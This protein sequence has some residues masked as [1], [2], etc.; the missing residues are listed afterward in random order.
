MTSRQGRGAFG[1][2]QKLV[3]VGSGGVGKSAIT[4]RF[5]TSQFYDQAYNPTIEDSYR[6]Q[7]VVDDEVVTLEIL[8]TAGQEE[9]GAMAD[10]WYRYGTGFLL[11]YS[12]TDRPTFEALAGLHQNILRVKDKEGGNVPCVVVSNKA[13]GSAY[14]Y[15]PCIVADTSLTTSQCDLARLRQVGQLEGRDLAKSFGAPFI[16]CSAADGV[17]VEIAFRELV[18]LVRRDERV[19]CKCECECECEHGYGFGYGKCSGV[20]RL[21]VESL[22]PLVK[23]R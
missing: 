11:V 13:S 19:R 8:D 6:K 20:L 22:E 16:E 7:F 12:I 3:I 23:P 17:N 5:C 2:E 18:K 1:S 15:C 21:R 9:Y 10:Q 14:S 4:I